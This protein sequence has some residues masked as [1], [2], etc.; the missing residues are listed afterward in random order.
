[1]KVHLRDPRALAVGAMAAL[2]T[3]IAAGV[4]PRPW[5]VVA[6]AAVAGIGGA[7]KWN[8]PDEPPGGAA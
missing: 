6:A 5:D 4:L 1:M 3:L 2:T 7:T 8:P